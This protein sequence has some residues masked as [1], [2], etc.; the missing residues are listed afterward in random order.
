LLLVNVEGEK[1]I[2]DLALDFADKRV[3]VILSVLLF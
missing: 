2:F 1:E 3:L